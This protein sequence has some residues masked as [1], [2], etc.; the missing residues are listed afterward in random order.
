MMKTKGRMKPVLFLY[1]GISIGSLRIGKALRGFQ[2]DSNTSYLIFRSHSVNL[3]GNGFN[4][5]IW[6]NNFLY[7]RLSCRGLGLYIGGSS[8]S[9]CFMDG[10]MYSSILDVLKG[11]DS[12]AYGDGGISVARRLT[13]VFG[14]SIAFGLRCM[15][16]GSCS[17]PLYRSSHLGPPICNT[18]AEDGCPGGA[19]ARVSSSH[20]IS[21][22]TGSCTRLSKFDRH[23]H[24]RFAL[25]V[26]CSGLYCGTGSSGSSFLPRCFVIRARRGP[27]NGGGG[28]VCGNF[29]INGSGLSTSAGSA[30]IYA[31][32]SFHRTF[33]LRPY[34]SSSIS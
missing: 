33:P 24:K 29:A 14:T 21:K 32:S 25:R 2:N 12:F 19:P 23:R 6:S 31:S 22:G 8:F 10:S 11:L 7:V 13:C 9:S 26:P 15:I 16:S 3:V 5:G 34:A 28:A 17:N 27:H 1:G 4:K 30:R 18:A 20:I